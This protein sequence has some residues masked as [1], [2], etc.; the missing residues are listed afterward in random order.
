MVEFQK[1]CRY[2][3]LFHP[4]INNVQPSV[5]YLGIRLH[6]HR[7]NPPPIYTLYPLLYFYQKT[8]DK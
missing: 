3:S 5:D 1:S 8:A 2:N 7:D 4:K 6:R